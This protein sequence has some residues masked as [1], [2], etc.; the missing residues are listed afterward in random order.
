GQR[1]SDLVKMRWTD[2]EEFQGRPGINV[3]QKKTGLGIWIPFT[4]QQIPPTSSWK[5]RPGF[6]DL[7]EAAHPS[8]RPQLS[9]QWLRERDTRPALAPLKE[10][11]RVLHGLRGTAC[12]RLLRAGANTRQIGDMVGMSEVMVKRYCRFSVQR[13]NALAAVHYLDRTNPEQLKS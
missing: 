6:S 1:G 2:L 13:E 7:K 11:G 5:R 12:V 9:A 4:H 3:R 8:P 10:A